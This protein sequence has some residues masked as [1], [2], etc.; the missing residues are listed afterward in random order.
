MGKSPPTVPHSISARRSHERIEANGLPRIERLILNPRT[1]IPSPK[2]PRYTQ[3]RSRGSERRCGG[4]PALRRE[5]DAVSVGFSHPSVLPGTQVA[6]H[7]AQRPVVVRISPLKSLSLVTHAVRVRSAGGEPEASVIPMWKKSS[8]RMGVSPVLGTVPL[9][10]TTDERATDVDQR[11]AALEAWEAAS[12]ER[13]RAA[14]EILTAADERDAVADARD[15]AADQRDHDHGLADFLAAADGENGDNLQERRAAALDRQQAKAER[16]AARRDR[17]A[18]AQDRVEP[19]DVLD[20]SDPGGDG[21]SGRF[22]G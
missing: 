10:R 19:G 9:D 14:Q 3:L 1:V 15:L 5:D 12:A 22:V 7:E 20:N 21:G 4:L 18:L 8:R 2:T 11:I 17:I 6:V 16:R 13:R